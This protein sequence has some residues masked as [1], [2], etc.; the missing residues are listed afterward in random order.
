MALTNVP[1]SDAI[2]VTDN[3]ARLKS[4]NMTRSMDI[5]KTINIFNSMDQ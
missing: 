3:A 1:V 4:P 5:T 2:R